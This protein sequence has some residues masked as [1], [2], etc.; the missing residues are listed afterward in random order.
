MFGMRDS[1]PALPYNSIGQMMQENNLSLSAE[2]HDRS[3]ND[4]ALG[5]FWKH[6][7][8]PCETLYV[9]NQD[10]PSYQRMPLM[11]LLCLRNW[12]TKPT[13]MSTDSG[14]QERT[15]TFYIQFSRILAFD[16]ASFS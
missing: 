16:I 15:L 3:A 1:D 10:D 13:G 12:S 9:L 2:R 14:S 11:G 8:A 4:S 6:A 5:Y 7:C